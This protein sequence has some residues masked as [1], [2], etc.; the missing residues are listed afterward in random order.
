MAISFEDQVAIV[1]GAGNG[2]GVAT[3]SVWPGEGPP[4]WSTTWPID[5]GPAPADSV[6]AEIN[7]AGGRAVANQDSVSEAK[8]GAAI[9]ETALDAFGWVD[10]VINNAG[11]L[12]DSSFAKLTHNGVALDLVN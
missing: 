8:G 7:P 9:T 2:L 10:I 4:W 1:T 3:R 6:G 11:I 5:G 12:R